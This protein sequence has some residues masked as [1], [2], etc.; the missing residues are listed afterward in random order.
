MRPPWMGVFL[1]R[2]GPIA[3]RGRGEENSL[4][5]QD[6]AQV[7]S[8]ALRRSV[9]GN[10]FFAGLGFGFAAS[11]ESEAILLDGFF[12]LVAFVLSLL[13]IRVAKLV[14]GPADEWF[15]FGYA[16]FEPMLNTVKGLLLLGV[17]GFSLVSAI[18]ALL[19]GGRDLNPGWALIYAVVAAGGAGILALV[20]KR[21]ARTTGSPLLAVDVKNWKI[22]SLLSIGVGAAFLVAFLLRESDWSELLPYVDPT[23]VILLVIAMLRDPIKIVIEGVGELLAVS[24]DETIQRQVRDEF[25][26][27]MESYPVRS[28]NL[29]MLKAGRTHY[30]LAHVVVEPDSR[31]DRIREQD[32]LRKQITI[33]LTEVTSTVGG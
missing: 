25:A 30:L 8:R 23:L 33:G 13:T 21:A 27:Q 32:A 28:F 12:S 2:S 31:I 1:L 19:H 4:S 6:S 29:R 26:R 20:Q 17:C 22:D 15:H 14:E 7:E 24:P 3:F 16:A 10:L 18:N 11:S 9:W 5:T